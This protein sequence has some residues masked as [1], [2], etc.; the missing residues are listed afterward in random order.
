MRR[1]PRRLAVV[2]VSLCVGVGEGVVVRAEA[3][4]LVVEGVTDL[5]H[6]LHVFPQDV[7]PR[8]EHALR[9]GIEVLEPGPEGRGCRLG[10]R[11]GDV[12]HPTFLGGRFSGCVYRDT[13]AFVRLLCIPERC[14][15]N[16]YST[17]QHT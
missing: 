5:P 10:L 8:G 12:L 9:R 6:L 4:H 1:K 15:F 3:A 13:F 16:K 11:Q 7:V 14:P 17:V 2:V